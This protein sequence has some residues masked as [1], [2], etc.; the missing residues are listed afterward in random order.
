MARIE[1][2]HHRL[3]RWAMWMAK[4]GGM[5]SGYGYHPMW[6]GMRVDGGDAVALVPINDE[7]CSQ[8]HD[9]INSLPDPIGQTVA[10]YYLVDAH[11]TQKRLGISASVMCQ[12]IDRGHR[13]LDQAFIEAKTKKITEHALPSWYERVSL[14]K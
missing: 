1:H 9:A 4:G 13:L 14:H 8:T 6:A 3:E 2:I 5:G 10:L 7:E 12:R 11:L